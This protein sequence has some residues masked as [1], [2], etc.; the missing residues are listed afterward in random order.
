LANPD[1]Q[2]Y[3]AGLVADVSTLDG[4][5]ELLLTDYVLGWCDAAVEEVT[6][7][8]P[9]SAI[10]MSLL[11]TCFCESCQQGASASGLDTAMARRAA[12]V[13]LHKSGTGETS[14]E[15]G[16]GAAGTDAEPLAAYARWRGEA[17]SVLLR[18][19]AGACGCDLVVERHLDR[20]FGALQG[21]VA[22]NVPGGVITAVN[23]PGQLKDA[24]C[25]EAQRNE[26]RL[27]A[28]MAA[29]TQGPELVGLLAESLELGFCGVQVDRYGILPDAAWVP[30]RQAVR[31]A[32]R[33]V[34]G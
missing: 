23:R 18:R 29:A 5:A 28:T 1:V 9:T 14:G 6:V 25:A 4:V 34:S 15:V 2:A 11:S 33:A 24:R 32:R 10:T 22:W 21:D 12:E 8:P 20:V 27:T 30:I 7:W 31:F 26:L 13:L 3:L 17:L 16:T 19:L